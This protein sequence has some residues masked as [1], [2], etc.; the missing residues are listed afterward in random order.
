MGRLALNHQRIP[1]N[2]AFF[3][4]EGWKTDPYHLNNRCSVSSSRFCAIPI[5]RATYNQIVRK[6]SIHA[7]DELV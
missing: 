4:S 2:C 7:A 1:K 3:H 6:L 5:T